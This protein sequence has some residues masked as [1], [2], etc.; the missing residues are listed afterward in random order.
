MKKS[1]FFVIP[2]ILLLVL[3][4]IFS[5]FSNSSVSSEVDSNNTLRNNV[6]QIEEL[7]TNL[8]T[9]ANM[10][11]NYLMTGNIEYKTKYTN[12]LN[13]SYNTVNVLTS[14]SILSKAQST[15][16]LDNLDQYKSLNESLTPLTTPSQANEEFQTTV[17]NMNQIEITISSA[18]SNNV[19]NSI[20]TMDTTANGIV[21]TTN[22]QVTLS[23]L[24]STILT[25][26]LSVPIYFIKKLGS[27]PSEIVENVFDNIHSGIEEPISSQPNNIPCLGSEIKEI[28]NKLVERSV[29]LSFLKTLYS[30]NDYMQDHWL[31]ASIILN[32]LEENI[33][34]LTLEVSQLKDSATVISPKEVEEI[35]DKI[36][37]LQCLFLQLPNYHNFVM[38]LIK[39][40]S[41]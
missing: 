34:T 8:S 31:Q 24:L 14:T 40:I 4:N 11:K 41:I 10:E 25:A 37:Q 7:R 6:K 3:L 28:E 2:T 30:H 26:L 35:K 38:E 32:E 15:A 13:E 39:N 22:T 29:L 17:A 16:I 5:Y 36:N 12:S 9:M 18:L 20:Q 23:G 21:N 33:N 19:L 1:L 27:T